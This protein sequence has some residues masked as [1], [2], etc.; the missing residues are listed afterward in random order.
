MR[1]NRMDRMDSK[2]YTSA[3]LLLYWFLYLFSFPFILLFIRTLLNAHSRRGLNDCTDY[4]ENLEVQ[5]CHSVSLGTKQIIKPMLFS[6]FLRFLSLIDQHYSDVPHRSQ[7]FQ[8]HSYLHLSFHK[9]SG[10][11]WIRNAILPQTHLPYRYVIY[12]S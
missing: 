6:R 2:M 3:F 11:V 12:S 8:L 9:M 1:H 5:G 7:Q 10:A 4:G